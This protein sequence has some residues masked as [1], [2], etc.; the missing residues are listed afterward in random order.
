MGEFGGIEEN[1]SRSVVGAVNVS[2]VMLVGGFE[3][4]KEKYVVKMG[5]A[6][7]DVGRSENGE[8]ED[9]SGEVPVDVPGDN[10]ELPE[11]KL[12]TETGEVEIIVEQTGKVKS[13][14]THEE[15]PV[16][17][18]RVVEDAVVRTEIGE[19]N[20]REGGAQVRSDERGRGKGVQG[21]RSEVHREQEG[22]GSG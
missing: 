7:T 6:K 17:K 14:D 12:A 13:V 3:I 10:E 8:P 5:E 21:L 22:G 1:E 4:V 2:E 20:S 9:K 18:K 15:T 19:G 11:K 16:E